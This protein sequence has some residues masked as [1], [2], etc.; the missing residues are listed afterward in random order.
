MLEPTNN[1]DEWGQLVDELRQL[2]DETLLQ[3]WRRNTQELDRTGLDPAGLRRRDTLRLQHYACRF[4][5]M[6]RFG[7]VGHLGRRTDAAA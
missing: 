6:E 2:E 1:P 7:A 5:A 3:V 4:V